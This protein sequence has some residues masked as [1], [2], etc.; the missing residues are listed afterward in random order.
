MLEWR[1]KL[2]LFY[3]QQ[4]SSKWII[5]SVRNSFSFTFI[6]VIGKHNLLWS[7]SLLF[8]NFS[9]NLFQGTNSIAGTCLPGNDV[10]LVPLVHSQTQE[11][12]QIGWCICNVRNI[13]LIFSK[14]FWTFELVR[15]V[16]I[17]IRRMRLDMGPRKNPTLKNLNQLQYLL[18]GWQFFHISK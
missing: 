4:G 15:N 14:R 8:K 9:S 2:P 10:Y 6:H 16:F 18:C 1:E 13:C 11:L 7:F 17:Y 5:C 12:L 3:S